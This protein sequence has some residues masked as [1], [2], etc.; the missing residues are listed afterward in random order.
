MWLAIVLL[1]SA[2]YAESCIVVTSDQMLETKEQ[3]FEFASQ[4]A[5]VAL[6][7]PNIYQARPFCQ[8]IKMGVNT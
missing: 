3:C 1:C 4:K 2:P 8:I 6:K 7:N 5:F